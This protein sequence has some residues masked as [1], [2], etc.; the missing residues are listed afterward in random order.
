[1]FEHIRHSDTL[2]DNSKTGQVSRERDTGRL[3]NESAYG[4]TK[5]DFK[6]AGNS[7]ALACIKPLTFK[8][9]FSI[10]ISSNLHPQLQL[11]IWL[12]INPMMMPVAA[13]R[14]R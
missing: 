2:T 7:H 8:R 13:C 3:R 4:I 14:Q 5:P 1:R 12:R 11:K 10:R 6:Q 9:G